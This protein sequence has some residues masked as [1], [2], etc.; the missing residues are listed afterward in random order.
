[1]STK[2]KFDPRSIKFRLWIYFA[3]IGLSV[4]AFIWF[5]QIFFMNN[6]YE[7]M[8]IRE[9][10]R[11]ATS[12]SHAYQLGDE[13]LTAY[14][15]ELSVSNDFYVMMESQNGLLLFS[16][17]QESRVPLSLYFEQTPKL[18]DLLLS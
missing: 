9:V 11:V 12:I 1:M 10:V 14:I 8:K 7:E 5:L 17:E 2:I 3:A 4:V 6:Y 13:D 16:P 15:Q 18:N